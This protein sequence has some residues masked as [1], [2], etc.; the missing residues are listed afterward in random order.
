MISSPVDAPPF[1]GGRKPT[2]RSVRIVG[3]EDT[4]VGV[5]EKQTRF[6]REPTDQTRV[7]VHLP[8]KISSRAS[9]IPPAALNTMNSCLCL[10]HG[11]T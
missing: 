8:P 3:L 9:T 1:L 6:T 7:G 2:P 10:S 4:F 11:L 5:V